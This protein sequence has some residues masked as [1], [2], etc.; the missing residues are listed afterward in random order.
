MRAPPGDTGDRKERR[1]K[2]PRN[3]EHLIHKAAVKVD[4]GIDALIDLALAGDDARGDCLD[5]LVEG[6][7]I[8][9]VLLLGE[10][11]HKSL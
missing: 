4:I 1:I 11:G 6:E 7:L 5:I 2:L 9:E 8:L 3:T 10:L